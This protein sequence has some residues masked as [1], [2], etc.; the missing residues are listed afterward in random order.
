MKLFH[1]RLNRFLPLSALPVGFNKPF[2]R[3]FMA[4]SHKD[5]PL[6][7]VSLFEDYIYPLQ[8]GAAN[9]EIRIADISDE[10]GDNISKKECELF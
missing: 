8:V 1:I 3:I 9:T 4:K 2:I 5:R 7:N 6:R 10:K